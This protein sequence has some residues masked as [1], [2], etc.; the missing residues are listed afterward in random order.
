MKR[1]EF[2]GR[3]L[4]VGAVAATGSAWD[5]GAITA[6]HRQRRDPAGNRLV[7]NG[8]DPSVLSEEYVEMHRPRRAWHVWHKSFGN[9]RSFADAYNFID[10]HPDSI[11]AVRSVADIMEAKR[12]GKLGL[13]F[14]W[15][16]ANPMSNGRGRTP[17][18]FWGDPPEDGAASLLRAGAQELRDRLSKSPTSLAAAPWTAT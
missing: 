15:Q 18:T 14:G 12:A 10:G 7:I 2:V 11:Q 5:R 4:T 16:S 6:L 1:R 9:V 13:F 8:L 17:M 3:S